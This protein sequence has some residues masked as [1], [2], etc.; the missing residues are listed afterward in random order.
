MN[1][2]NFKPYKTDERAKYILMH[3]YEF[4]NAVN[5]YGFTPQKNTSP[6]YLRAKKRALKITKN[7]ADQTIYLYIKENL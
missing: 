5:C 1:L 7:F 3:S 2:E 4:I 6:D